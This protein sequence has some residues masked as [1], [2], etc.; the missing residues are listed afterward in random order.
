MG[1]LVFSLLWEMSYG[2]WTNGKWGL[3]GFGGFGAIGLDIL[4]KER[5]LEKTE[6][7]HLI[8]LILYQL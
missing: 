3:D 7:N 6:D 8:R 4:R 5:I 2:K 1:F